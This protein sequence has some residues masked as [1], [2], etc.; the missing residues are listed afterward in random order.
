MGEE[1][2]ILI[3]KCI[4]EGKIPDDD[5]NEVTSKKKCQT[6][7]QLFKDNAKPK[8]NSLIAVVEIKRLFQDYMILEQFV[9]KATLLMDEAGYPAGHKDRM[10]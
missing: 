4:T 6:Y 3:S 2:S 8:S 5:D 9:I 10:V 7:W 1:G